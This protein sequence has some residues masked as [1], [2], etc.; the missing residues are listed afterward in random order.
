MKDR[1]RLAQ[2][3]RQAQGDLHG[4]YARQTRQERAASW[5]LLGWSSHLV[6]DAV[7]AGPLDVVRAAI[8]DG[9]L[10]TAPKRLRRAAFALSLIDAYTALQSPREHGVKPHRSRALAQ[11]TSAIRRS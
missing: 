6:L 4:I 10:S 9:L 8:R 2:A 3:I 1:P 5:R 7:G 11:T